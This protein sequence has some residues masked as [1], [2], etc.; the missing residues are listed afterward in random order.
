MEPSS[1][2]A[3]DLGNAGERMA[4]RF[5]EDRGYREIARNVRVGADEIDLVVEKGMVTVA[6]EVKATGNGDDPLLALDEA[7]FSRFRRAA[8]AMPMRIDRLDIVAVRFEREGVMVRW[9]CGVI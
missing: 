3:R 9:L 4:V 8:A 2:H 6:V 1:E 5:L 7:K